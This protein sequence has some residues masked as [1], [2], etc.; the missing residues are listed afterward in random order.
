MQ[1]QCDALD[2]EKEIEESERENKFY[3]KLIEWSKE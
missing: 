2:I 3:E 1:I